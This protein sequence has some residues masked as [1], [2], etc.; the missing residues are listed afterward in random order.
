M[1]YTLC[2]RSPVDTPG[3]LVAGGIS[4]HQSIQDSGNHGPHGIVGR[5]LS[6]T[7]HTIQER[8]KFER[9]LYDVHT[10]HQAELD[11]IRK[12]LRDDYVIC[13]EVGLEGCRVVGLCDEL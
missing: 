11:Y 10:V 6:L 12:V 7:P 3:Y 2:D 4:S 9:M 1:R 5:S 8:K 13:D